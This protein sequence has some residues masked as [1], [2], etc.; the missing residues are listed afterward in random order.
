MSTR[1]PAESTSG[2]SQ[3]QASGTLNA[4]ELGELATRAELANSVIQ[5]RQLA[6]MSALEIQERQRGLDHQA[7]LREIENASEIGRIEQESQ[8]AAEEMALRSTQHQINIYATVAEG[9]AKQRLEELN[10]ITK[11]NELEQQLA[12][13]QQGCISASKRTCCCKSTFIGITLLALAIL[14]IGVL[15]QKKVRPF[16]SF[17]PITARNL[18]ISG[19]TIAGISIASGLAASKIKQC[20]TQ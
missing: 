10:N 14:T 3:Q 9:D 1:I 18:I 13:A 8:Y 20:T 12:S 6:Q 5:S 11:V 4:E 17:S 16:D 7:K 19:A 2:S 15:A